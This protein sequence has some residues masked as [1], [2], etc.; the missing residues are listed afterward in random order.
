MTD[1][2]KRFPGGD[3]SADKDKGFGQQNQNPDDMNENK[4]R[5]LAGQNQQGGQ[6][7]NQKPTNPRQ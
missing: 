1:Q 7:G 4:N 3:K 6:S 5:G 2:N